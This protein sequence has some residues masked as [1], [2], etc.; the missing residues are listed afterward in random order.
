MTQAKLLVF[1]EHDF[2]ARHFLMS[3]AFDALARVAELLFVFP[4]S[5][6]KRF[7]LDPATLP[8]PAPFVRIPVDAQRQVRWRWLF[9]AEQLRWRPGAD[10]AALR[11]LRR[12][13]LG[14]KAAN[15]LTF[16]GLPGIKPIF[17]RVVRRQIA[18]RPNRA[19]ERLIAETTPA[20]LIHP[21]VL[22][23]HFIN[24]LVEIGA[25]RGVPTVAIMN[26]W[27]N[28]STKRAIVGLPDWLLVWGGQTKMHAERYM[29]MPPERVVSFGAAQLDVFREPARID[30]AEFCTRHDA[31]P[32]LPLILYAGSS[33]GADEFAQLLALEQAIDAGTAPA[34]TIVY[35]PH[36]WG[37]GGHEGGRTLHQ[38]WRHVRIEATMRT[39]LERVAAGDRSASLPDYRDTHDTLTCVDAVISPLSTILIEAAMHAKP[40]LC[41][42]PID[43]PGA[44]HFRLAQGLP[45]FRDIIECPD[46]MTAEGRQGLLDRFPQLVAAARE[47][48]AGEAA[49]AASRHFV[50]PFAEPWGERLAAFV[51]DRVLVRR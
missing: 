29:R 15:L 30:R 33:K 17:E 45:C 9:F 24:D 26:S 22:E 25:A 1:V 13:S 38:T 46:F 34:A 44:A 14:R 40:V 39:Y 5:G 49:R 3:R 32:S 43:E 51:N 48:A 37:D 20:A 4:A 10:A 21:S 50:E 28:P 31:D 2:V 18:Q 41:Q 35:R 19:L 42:L 16:A 7:T 27:D 23:G 47:P 12:E 36:P 8:L 6:N 11:R